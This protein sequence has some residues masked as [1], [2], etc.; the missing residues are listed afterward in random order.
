MHYPIT[1]KVDHAGNVWTACEYDAA[2]T[3]GSAQ[4]YSSGGTLTSTYAEGPPT[5]PPS[6]TCSFSSYGFDE[7]SNATDV[8]DAVATFLSSVCSPKCTKSNGSG[9]EY[10]LQGRRRRRRR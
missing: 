3:G 1:V 10:G 4:E 8:F 6:A 2:F 7:A 5:C 9:F